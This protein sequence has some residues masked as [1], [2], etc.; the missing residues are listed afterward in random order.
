MADSG[1]FLYRDKPLVRRG[2]VMYYGYMQKEVV[3]MLTVE[4]SHDFKDIKISDRVLLQLI[5]TDS[6][7]SPKDIVLKYTV[8]DG[9]YEALDVANIWI[10]RYN[11]KS[12]C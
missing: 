1:F 4:E 6:N 12:G 7:V 8:K 5:S 9:L 2:N 10:D 3:A 11:K